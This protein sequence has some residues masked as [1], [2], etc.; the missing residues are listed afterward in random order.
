MCEKNNECDIQNAPTRCVCQHW[1]RTL[2]VVMQ[3]ALGLI[4]PSLELT[5]WTGR[6]LPSSVPA[7]YTTLKLVVSKR[8]RTSGWTSNAD[9]AS[10]TSQIDDIEAAVRRGHAQTADRSAA[11]TLYTILQLFFAYS[12]RTALV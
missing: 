6:Q 5:G 10:S 2:V 4:I 11:A 12:G 3:L 1:P 7:V 9:G 8:S